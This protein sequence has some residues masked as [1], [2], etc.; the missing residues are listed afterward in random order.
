MSRN[1]LMVLEEMKFEK[2]FKI[3]RNSSLE[4]NVTSNIKAVP[5]AL[6]R[7]QSKKL[8][9]SRIFYFAWGLEFNQNILPNTAV[10]GSWWRVLRLMSFFYFIQFFFQLWYYPIHEVTLYDI[11]ISYQ[12]KTLNTFCC[13][14]NFTKFITIFFKW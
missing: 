3:R 9:F 4:T 5:V 1:N 7:W 11:L 8:T 2:Y 10:L 6:K 12:K 13:F 14:C